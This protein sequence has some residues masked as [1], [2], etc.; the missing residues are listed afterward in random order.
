MMLIRI[1]SPKEEEI[2]RKISKSDAQEVFT[3]GVQNS[4]TT[5]KIS[6]ETS[7]HCWGFW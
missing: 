1:L 6:N 3:A 4:P 5:K 7:H 2:S